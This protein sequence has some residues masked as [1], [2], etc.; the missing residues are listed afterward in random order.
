MA[1]HFPPADTATDAT[2]S[3][4]TGS[5]TD[6]DGVAWV[7][8]AG[9]AAT[10]ADGFAHWTAEVPIALGHEQLVVATADRAGNVELHAASVVIENS[11][12]FLLF[13]SAFARDA[14]S[15]LFYAA[16]RTSR[17]IIEI[18]PVTGWRR[19][20]SSATLGH[21]APLTNPQ[22]LA[23]L[24]SGQSLLVADDPDELIRVDLATGDRTVITSGGIGSGTSMLHPRAV[25]Y[26]PALGRAFV[27]TQ[28]P[29][30][31]ISVDV[32]TGARAV[33]TS[34]TVGGGVP[35]KALAG[36]AYDAGAKRFYAVDRL[37]RRLLAIDELTGFRTTISDP[38]VGTGPTFGT[39]YGVEFDAQ[40]ARVL[41]VD[42]VTDAVLAV[43]VTTG[44]R[45]TI[46]STS[47]GTSGGAYDAENCAQRLLADANGGTVQALQFD[48]IESIDL[49]TSQHTWLTSNARGLGQAPRMMPA[50]SRPV[51]DTRNERF[52]VSCQPEVRWQLLSVDPLTGDRAD[53]P[54]D[55]SVTTLR[56]PGG[57]A[58]ESRSGLVVLQREVTY[59]SYV[60]VGLDPITGATV[61]L[62]TPD[63]FI[64]TQLA[65][66]PH[67]E[68]VFLSNYDRVVAF[69]GQSQQWST[70]SSSSVGTGPALVWLNGLTYDAVH[71][72]LYATEEQSTAQV[73]TIDPT[74][75]ART[76]IASKTVG[77]GPVPLVPRGTA[78]D[79]ARNRLIVADGG[80]DALLA[81]DLTTLERRVL[82][83]TGDGKAVDPLGQSARDVGT[84]PTFFEPLGIDLDAERNVAYVTQYFPLEGVSCVELGSGD[85]VLISR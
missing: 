17:S 41:V 8:V 70:V 58:F 59:G 7:R 33:L 42:S 12:P 3:H 84:G 72:V 39:V 40:H 11:G 64:S 55:D 65:L 1:L 20:V 50:T 49:A 77:S 19:T 62:S 37:E 26:V 44:D 63:A 15:G 43:D 36:L 47:A 69:D 35:Y 76:T 32:N 21:G 10:S 45:T 74:T 25:D 78:L 66:D 28:Q 29:D 51:R 4:V 24:Q 80:W 60:L 27:M 52:L 75:G 13:A 18:D 6:P 38:L 57:V 23:I 34:S 79:L 81:I 48:G 30:R 22:G 68:R 31:I 61:D 16:D 54:V 56:F 73:L 83:K 14:Q 53:L 82:T 5:A 9:I 46:A 67:G 2:T 85:R 71:D